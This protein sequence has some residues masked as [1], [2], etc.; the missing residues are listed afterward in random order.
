MPTSP[1][2]LAHPALGDLT[3]VI[4]TILRPEAVRLVVESF[5]RVLGEAVPILVVDDSPVPDLEGFPPQ[6]S[7]IAMPFDIGISAGRNRGVESVRTSRVFL[8]DDDC[9]LESGV[10]EIVRCLELLDVGWD[11]IGSGAH[12]LHARDGVLHVTERL[13]TGDVR[14]CCITKNFFLAKTD[15]LRRVPWDERMK[16]CPEH[17]D[18]FLRL[19]QAGARIGGTRLLRF[20]NL[21][22]GN[23]D[24]RKLRSRN[25]MNLFREKWNLRDVV[26]HPS[27]RGHAREQPRW[28][29]S[30]E[31]RRL[32]VSS[33]RQSLDDWLNIGDPAGEG[34]I[35]RCELGGRLPFAENTFDIAYMDRVIERLDYP[36]GMR[37]LRELWRVL[38]P[39]ARLRVA[40]F[41][42]NFLLSLGSAGPDSPGARYLKWATDS[43]I[44][45]APG[46]DPT[47]VFN[48][49][50]SSW[51]H[52]FLHD[53]T[54]LADALDTVGFR[55]VVRFEPGQSLHSSFRGLDDEGRLPYG[56][57]RL[58]TLILEAAK[59]I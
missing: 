58:E 19:G 5:S 54:T 12:D 24:Y 43:F 41:D 16:T 28:F 49:Y 33:G 55:N 59:P 11:L 7:V 56:F 25:F 14:E 6:V 42:F 20:R 30:G 40:T 13:I 44:N 26:W 48:H 39:G 47:F 36:A 29:A 8:A 35:Y 2:L 45:W 23:E 9:L 46:Y 51:S 31:L 38:R 57:Y 3:V 53:E 22:W 34:W 17:A 4:K 1:Q 32:H 10:A 15:L 21:G 52:R 37:L 18:H 50:M 27:G